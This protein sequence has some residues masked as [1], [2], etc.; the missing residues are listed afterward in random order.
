MKS[1]S[2]SQAEVI[3]SQ[4]SGYPN[5]PNGRPSGVL[6]YM[7][8]NSTRSSAFARKAGGHVRKL[9]A[10]GQ[11]E[12]N[13]TIDK[14]DVPYFD[15]ASDKPCELYYAVIETNP[16]GIIVATLPKGT[17]DAHARK[18]RGKDEPDLTIT[19]EFGQKKQLIQLLTQ[20]SAPPD[21]SEFEIIK[22]PMARREAEL[23]TLHLLTIQALLDYGC[24]VCIE[25]MFVT[26]KR[27]TMEEHG[28]DF[29]REQDRIIRVDSFIE[30]AVSKRRPKEAI[31]HYVYA[32]HVTDFEATLPQAS[33]IIEEKNPSR[34]GE[35]YF[36]HGVFMTLPQMRARLETASQQAANDPQLKDSP[37]IAGELAST[38][39]RL[40]LMERI[41]RTLVKQLRRTG[42]RL[43]TTLGAGPEAV[44]IDSQ[45]YTAHLPQSAFR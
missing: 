30:P 36:E 44:A 7:L 16:T 13:E 9:A 25:P 20:I 22:D 43:H 14:I 1:A 35:S 3:L 11:P 34:E 15:P 26:A 37:L 29:T 39:S 32:A 45:L 40:Q 5:L 10:D 28:F 6:A 18:I 33:T 19:V 21:L 17:Q 2:P 42:I 23:N 24:E 38:E 8:A 27:E 12:A 41:E 31:D 4:F